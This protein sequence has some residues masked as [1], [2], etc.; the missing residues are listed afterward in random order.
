MLQFVCLRRV[1]SAILWDTSCNPLKLT[2][3]SEE[4]VDSIFRAE[5]QAKQET[6]LN[7]VTR[8]CLALRSACCFLHSSS[9]LDY[10]STLTMETLCSSET[11]VD[12]QR[13]TRRYFP[14]RTLLNH[15]CENLKSY[16]SDSV[17]PCFQKSREINKKLIFV[18]PIAFKHDTSFITRVK[19][20][21]IL[22][23][24][25]FTAVQ[26]QT[27]GFICVSLRTY[28]ERKFS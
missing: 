23:D 1:R 25:T 21:Y 20:S 19:T 7:Q 22:N 11:S 9:C 26:T 10:S 15:R 3:V 27:G 4:H 16:F 28:H 5:E 2:D 24:F 13:Y 8:F 6:S 14:N 17:E 12:F 18:T